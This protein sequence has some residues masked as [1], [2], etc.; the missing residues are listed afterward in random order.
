MADR[1][2]ENWFSNVSFLY[3]YLLRKANWGESVGL[4][5]ARNKLER[6]WYNIDYKWSCITRLLKI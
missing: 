5:I 6:I 3:V 2:N 1:N 4:P